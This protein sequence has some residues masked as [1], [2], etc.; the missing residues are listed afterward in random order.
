M[1]HATRR[2]LATALALIM[3][4]GIVPMAAAEGGS[5]GPIAIR[6]GFSA[7]NL[8]GTYATLADAEENRGT[9]KWIVITGDYTLEED[10]T[11]PADVFL[12]VLDGA[13]L[14]VAADKTLTVAADCKRLG[15]R[16]SGKIVNNGTIVVCGTSVD[17]G[18]VALIG[19]ATLDTS[20]LSVPNGYFLD[21]NGQTNFYASK[22]A[23]EIEYSD[24]T[25]EMAG[26]SLSNLTDAKKLTLLKDLDNFSRTFS[27]TDMLAEGFVLDLGDHTITGTTTATNVLRISVPMTI[28][29]GKIQYASDDKAGA[30][31]TGKD[32][33][34]AA[35]VIIDGGAGYG[36]WTEGY[37]H[38]LTVNGTVRSDGGYAITGNGSV[39]GDRIAECNI[40]VNTGAKIEAPN[41]IGIYHPELGTVTINGGKISGS[42]GVQMCAGKL[43]V[44]DGEITS[45]GANV[46]H[47]GSQN[48]MADGAA[49]S[50]LNRNYPGGTPTAEIIDGTFRATGEGAHALRAYSYKNEQVEPWTDVLN[51]VKLTGGAYSTNPSD[52]LQEGYTAKQDADELY[53]LQG[54][55]AELTVSTDDGSTT[56]KYANI[57]T[58]LS[59]WAANGGT[60]KLLANC[61]TEAGEAYP[62]QMIEVS[63]AATLDLNGYELVLSN[64]VDSEGQSKPYYAKY[65]KAS[66]PKLTVESSRA[67]GKLLGWG[68]SNP[69][70]NAANEIVIG[71][72]VEIVNENEEGGAVKASDK[73]EMNGGKLTGKAY[74]LSV[75]RFDATIN[76]GEIN[77]LTKASGKL[78]L[79]TDNGAYTDVKIGTLTLNSNDLT[80]DFK[81]GIVGILDT[82][83]A[84]TLNV[85]ENAFFEQKFTQGVPAGK[86][87]KA[88]TKDGKNYYQ[89]VALDAENA[90]AI[91]TKA[92]GTTQYYVDAATAAAA[93]SAGDTLTLCEDYT[94]R[95]KFE[96]TGSITID[97]GGK[98][99]TNPDGPALRITLTGDV[100]AATPYQVNVKNGKLVSGNNVA[101]QIDAANRATDV[102]VENVEITSGAEKPILE[103]QGQARIAFTDETGEALL[104]KY[105]N[106]F[107]VSDGGKKYFYGITN[108]LTPAAKAGSPVKLLADYTGTQK[109]NYAE[110]TGKDVVLDL[111]E[112]TYHYTYAVGQTALEFNEASSN[113]TV[114]N[115]TIVSDTDYAVYAFG[116]A[117]NL[118]LTLDGVNL[119]AENG[120]GLSVNGTVTGNET[121]VKN[122]KIEAGEIGIYYPATGTLNIENSEISG[123]KLG[124]ALKGGTTTISGAETKISAAA[125]AKAPGADYGGGSDDELTAEGYALYVE[126][127]YNDRNIVLHVTGGAFASK[128]DAIYR[129]VPDGDTRTR[130]IKVSGGYFTSDPREYKADG[131]YVVASDVDGYTYMVTDQTP[132]A[133]QKI[134]VVDK[135]EIN[136][137]AGSAL[138]DADKAK[139]SIDGVAEAVESSKKT[140][141]VTKA[142]ADSA[143]NPDAKVQIEVNVKVSVTNEDR[144]NETMTFT[145]EPYATVKVGD[146][147]SGNEVKVDNSYLNGKA[148]TV[149]LPL[150]TGFNPVQIK[151]T[152]SDGSGVEYF[153]KTP[154]SGAKTFTV[155]DGCAVFTIT[156]FSTFELSGT[157]TYV[158]PSSGSSSSGY[159]ITVDSAEH[160][161]VSASSTWASR[162][163][164]VTLTVKPDSGYVLETLTVLD[165]DGK[166]LKLTDKGD[167]KY[168]FTMPS[169]RVE[170]KAAFMEDNSVLNFFYDVPNDAYYYEA[171]KWAV[172][173]GITDGIGNNLFAPDQ[174][175]T[176]GQIVT[177]LWRA[178]GSPEPKNM[179]SFADV[180]ADSYYA[181]AV[182]WAMENGVTTGTT[183]ATFSPDA[184]CTRA[185]AVTFLARALNA[186]AASAAEF[187]D[188]PADSYYADA[189]AWAAANGVTEG[190]GGGLFA[191]DNDC[192]RGQ[193]VTFL[194]RALAK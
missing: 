73:I 157:V 44:N 169:G 125:A 21:R 12:D 94:G 118:K 69:V 51:Y 31:Y 149:K 122:S 101:L 28:Q 56:T 50:I 171:V 6:T 67:G 140:E 7:D 142:G 34:V 172:G 33:T 126:G 59:Q 4:I 163:A 116:T 43:V 179:G 83:N 49:I 111:N 96:L 148:I 2:L 89:L 158:E 124:V 3:A 176:R 177:F 97:L 182:A 36:I 115:G 13:T 85:T 99:V 155:E 113:L 184:V 42:T 64:G 143:S 79:G 10:F 65:I 181:K 174:P 88:V 130:E 39:S 173:K 27:S 108:G 138:T 60:L 134:T 188:V 166:E 72:N 119:K 178:A 53:R 61:E 58:A 9:N 110:N 86:G 78:S 45:S 30:V 167:G 185:Q 153:L 29:N 183:A 164:T 76:K 57:D 191:P 40:V 189:V 81:S 128:G 46:D 80:V 136:V 75:T 100:D 32:V 5:D 68:S 54:P 8:P 194:Y 160:G 41:G 62:Q 26:A 63:K 150:P 66:G 24:G 139:T 154:K 103:V 192:T 90:T 131:Y 102:V 71:E 98:T 16:D 17:N 162:G 159:A 104:A 95:L 144:A 156:K 168:T 114:K 22:A 120:Y 133:N 35:D 193:I 187:S 147:Q 151:H 137:P 117:S 77:I 74:G 18:K 93:A 47:T 145:A 87:L 165:K 105:G 55:V 38:T 20:I 170:V 141:I 175:C 132:S 123:E 23:F 161:S 129:F 107:T 82:S 121:T 52:Y 84:P 19:G 48:A 91:L 180:A 37:E 25:K 92:D 186:K 11:I 14:T 112:K 146:S 106:G 109:L 15:V 1:K 190:I 152:F 135:S 127:G 70:I